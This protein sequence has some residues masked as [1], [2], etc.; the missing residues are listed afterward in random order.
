MLYKFTPTGY[1]GRVAQISRG[2]WF[3]EHRVEEDGLEIF[4]C[5]NTSK[6]ERRMLLSNNMSH[7]DRTAMLNL[8][9]AQRRTNFLA[10]F[11]AGWFSFEL[12]NRTPALHRL[13]I[14]WRCLAFLGCT[15][16]LKQPFNHWNSTSYAPLVGAYL[17][18]YDGCSKTDA[19]EIKDRTREYYEI[20]DSQ[21][22]AY[23]EQDLAHEHM[24]ANHGPQP[25][26]EVFDGSYLAELD[27]F[28]NNE[29]NH[30]MEHRFFLKYPFE[31]QDKS[32][33]TQEAAK[34]LIT[35]KL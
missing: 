5:F 33:P 21:Y 32:F 13:A 18:K 35:G 26:G 27:K 19:F 29:P 30:L 2:P 1:F 6:G 12:I 14:G 4:F 11:A 25:D 34:D 22:M 31:F 15:Y 28:L 3:D 23:S 20:D 16:I 17:R 7:E 24:H 9:S 10:L 8:W